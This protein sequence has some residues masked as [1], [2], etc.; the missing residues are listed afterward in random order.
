MKKILKYLPILLVLLMSSCEEDFLDGVPKDKITEGSF[1]TTENDLKTYANG[2]YRCINTRRGSWASKYS[3]ENGSDNVLGVVEIGFPDG[4]IYRTSSDASSTNGTW[5][6]TYSW[7]R[8]IN[9]MISSLANYDLATLS[10]KGKQY[11]GEAY[12]FR[13]YMNFQLLSTFGGCPYIDQVLSIDDT[14]S[15]YKPRMERDDF[16]LTIMADL[17]RAIENLQWASA[18]GSGRI[19][20]EA[21][22]GYKAKFG[23]FEGSWEYYHQN[24]DFGATGENGTIFLEK[25]VDAGNKLIDKLGT[26]VFKGKA[27]FE[28]AGLFDKVDYSAIPE[29]LHYQ[30]Y[31][32]DEG[33]TVI[34]AN[35]ARGGGQVGLTKAAVDDY[36]MA[37]GEPKE[38]NTAEYK[39][40]DTFVNL[41][42]D[43]DPRLA[44]T[45]YFSEKWGS[46]GEILGWESLN[47][48]TMTAVTK[49]ANWYAPPSGYMFAKGVRS[50]IN[51]YSEYGFGEQGWIHLRYGEVLVAYAEAKAILEELGAGQLTQADLDKSINVLR[52]RV[53][54]GHMNLAAVKSWNSNPSY[55]KRYGN[56]SS[57]INEI[58][59][60]RRVE[61]VGEGQ[62]YDDLRRWRMLGHLINGYVPR[63]AKAQQFIDYWQPLGKL[64]ESDIHVD[65]NGYLL[66]GGLRSDFLE[67]GEGYKI[68][69]G[70]DYLWSI[71][72]NEINL[73]K[74]EADVVLT[75]N[76]GWN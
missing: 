75:Q 31:S 24:T 29:A 57:V 42:T 76:P 67:G 47:S 52:D 46:F 54:M 62:R 17:D 69:E 7:L 55:I 18:A 28:Y 8:N 43:R 30:L 10:D 14:E 38:I 33:I 4:K 27:G 59:R 74:S 63:G 36:L 44:Q 11:V 23:L 35:Y 2:L 66:P 51:E 45:V 64:N 41:T 60:E 72:K 1:W 39:G 37:N 3:V 50:D 48:Q 25:A 49:A 9:Y 61:L 40:D 53:G 56:V 26:N 20:K 68:D 71:P 65:A 73:Y 6:G 16:A 58:R 19:S 15:L 70:R 5:N 13:A 22:L 12:F 21:A 34:W 32:K